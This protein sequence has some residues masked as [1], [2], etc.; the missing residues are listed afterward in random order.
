MVNLRLGKFPTFAVLFYFGGSPKREGGYPP[1]GK[2]PNYFL[3]FSVDQ[4]EEKKIAE[5][6]LTRKLNNNYN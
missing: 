3:L 5:V 2:I 6:L 4:V 1:F